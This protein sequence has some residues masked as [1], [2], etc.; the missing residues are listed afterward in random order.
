MDDGYP[1]HPKVDKVGPLA[2]WLNVCAWAYAARNLTD[3]FVPL[4]RAARLA[5]VPNARV[6]VK[7]LVEAGLWESAAAPCEKCV[8]RRTAAGSAEL[9]EGYLVHDYLDYN[10]SK[11]QVLKE[12]VA[13]A[14]RV[15]DHRNARSNGVTPPDTNGGGNSVGTPSSTP[16]SNGVSTTAPLTS[17][18]RTPVNPSPEY[19]KRAKALSS[20]G[21]DAP[22][23]G[24]VPKDPR[25][26]EIDAVYAHYRAR[27]QPRS[28]LC[29]R[30]K[31]AARLKR[32]S[33]AQLIEGIDHFAADDWRMKH[34]V[35][36]ATWFFDSDGRSEQW[37]LLQAEAPP[38]AEPTAI[39]APPPRSWV[40]CSRCGR[41]GYS[42]YTEPPYPIA[43]MN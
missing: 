35:Y 16:V 18:S 8:A 4:E 22:A 2:A 3:G 24:E 29:P 9:D 14:Q 20:A 42:E 1:E 25:A 33:A 10:P 21:A 15:A 30:K 31:I 28:Q 19:E 27:V 6:L 41:K 23:P 36:N 32:F 17:P 38:A 12:R 11:A 13:T 43:A 34:N 40:T 37:L 7:K 5:A 26:D 39:P